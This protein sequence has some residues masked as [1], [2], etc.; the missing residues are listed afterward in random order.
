MRSATEDLMPINS[1]TDLTQFINGLITDN[2]PRFQIIVD[3][4][5][6]YQLTVSTIEKR[7]KDDFVQFEILTK[8]FEK[9]KDVQIFQKSF[10]F[11]KFQAEA[12]GSLEMIR[13]KFEELHSYNSDITKYIKVSEQLGL[14]TVVGRQ[15]RESLQ[16]KVKQ[17]QSALRVYLFALAEQSF[18]LITTSLDSIKQQ[19]EKTFDGLNQYVAYVKS[20]KA[21][22][23]TLEDLEKQKT[24]LEQMKSVL[25]KFR[26]EKGTSNFG[27]SNVSQLQTKI[28]VINQDLTNRKREVDEATE[29]A[30]LQKEANVEALGKRI[31][32]VKE[33]LELCVQNVE[34]PTTMSRK[35]EDKEDALKEL[36]SLK[37]KYDGLKEKINQF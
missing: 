6:Q 19:L 21:A 25:Q 32:E 27:N 15:L 2:A 16:K 30:T 34:T 8:D 26:E 23:A 10:V 18:K 9:C 33:G 22:K 35:L 13:A 4:S 20:L 24:E 14:I 3:D 17:E 28:E 37:K 29:R 1:Q 11:E 7:L 36:A 12:D 31:E 5:Y